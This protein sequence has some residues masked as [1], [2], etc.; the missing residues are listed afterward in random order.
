MPILYINNNKIDYCIYIRLLVS[1]LTIFIW[2]SLRKAFLARAD[3]L[4]VQGIAHCVNVSL[5]F[6]Q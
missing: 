2:L 3:K 4:L 1:N 5:L 6:F